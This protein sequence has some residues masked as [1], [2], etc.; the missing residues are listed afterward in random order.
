M[1][2]TQNGEFEAKEESSYRLKIRME[3]VHIQVLIGFT[4]KVLIFFLQVML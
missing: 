1:K 4:V 2:F 3:L